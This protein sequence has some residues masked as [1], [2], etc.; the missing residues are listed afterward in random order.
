MKKAV[1]A[2]NQKGELFE[3]NFED[4]PFY[5]IVND[6]NERKKIQDCALN[7]GELKDYVLIGKNAS[8]QFRNIIKDKEFDYI[9]L[10]FTNLDETLKYF[11][12]YS[13]K[14]EVFNKHTQ[15][16]EE[17][18]DK[19]KYVYLSEIEA[20]KKALPQKGRGIE[21]GVGSGRFAIPLGIKVGVEPSRKMGE[22]AKQNGIDV[23]FGVAE[24]LP[25]DDNSF[26]F[27]LMAVTICFVNDPL[28]SLKECYRILKPKGQIIVGI[29]DA[30]TPLGK[31]YLKKKE[32]SVF[33]KYARFFSSK[34]IL[35]LFEK[36]GFAFKQA[37]QVLFGDYGK[38][39]HIQEPKEGFSEGG[40]SVLV[41]EK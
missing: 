20:L 3:G 40:F 38:I 9:F 17:W 25:I 21:I 24:N 5:L 37:Y 31:V 32:N 35:D 23:I 19:N 41:G 18:F 10:D 34:E 6:K 28:K 39:N 4:S 30:D 16:Y 7:L 22:I 14:I 13:N 27:A 15:E 1:I 12:D 8:A 11:E 33:Y 36:S 26:D 2:I 29:V